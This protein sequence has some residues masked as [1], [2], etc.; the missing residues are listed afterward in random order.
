M[1]VRGKPRSGLLDAAGQHF[2]LPFRAQVGH[3]GA[4]QAGRRH[5]VF[6]N[7]NTES[8]LCKAEFLR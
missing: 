3:E 2:D 5:F 6:N 4:E 1:I 7:G 8:I